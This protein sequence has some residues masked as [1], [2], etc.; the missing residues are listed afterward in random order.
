MEHDDRLSNTQ[1]RQLIHDHGIAIALFDYIDDDKIIDEWL[2]KPIKNAKR[3]LKK[4]YD[5]LSGE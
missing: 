5:I 4:I 1:I 2:V 3:H